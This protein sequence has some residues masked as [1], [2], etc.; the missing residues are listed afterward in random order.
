MKN[1]LAAAGA[2]IVI[3]LGL[4]NPACAHTDL[5]KSSP[6]ADSTV[7]AP[8]VITLTFSE[9]VAPA[10]TRFELG[11]D[12]GMKIAFKT[13]ISADGKV[14]TCT[15]VAPMMAGAYKLTWHAAAAEDGHR[16]DGA[17]SFEV[18]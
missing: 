16:T 5:I 17:F 15:P 8:K 18:K 10:F 9:K 1:P 11:M 3:A 14:I 13:A 6:A 7:P 4:A 12:D 2:A